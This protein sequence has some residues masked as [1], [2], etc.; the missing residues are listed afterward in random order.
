MNKIQKKTAAISM[1]ALWLL[2]SSFVLAQSTGTTSNELNGWLQLI[3]DVLSAAVGVAFVVSF[4]I[5]GYQY[6]TARDDANQVKAAKDRI[7]TLVL[8][9]FVFAF[10]YALLQWL[11]PGGIFN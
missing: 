8:T 2:N 9:F 6:M 4:I 5:A 3:I 1:F 10:G 11:V 7:V